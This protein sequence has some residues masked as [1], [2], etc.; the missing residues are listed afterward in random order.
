[1]WILRTW[2]ITE[3]FWKHSN[4]FCLK[5]LQTIWKSARLKVKNV[6]LVMTKVWESSVNTLGGIQKVLL[7][8]NN[9]FYTVTYTMTMKIFTSSLKEKSM[10]IYIY[11]YICIHI[12]I[13]TFLI[14]DTFIHA[15]LGS[16]QQTLSNY[17]AVSIRGNS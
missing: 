8:Q 3:Y 1:M 11:I 6:F 15:G 16:E 14:K 13:Y 7:L 9:N 5:V 10:S 2:L 4:H 12:Y 17:Q